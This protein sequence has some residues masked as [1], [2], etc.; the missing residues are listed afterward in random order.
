MVGY[1]NFSE[2]DILYAEIFNSVWLPISMMI[3][4]KVGNDLAPGGIV[5]TLYLTVSNLESI[6]AFCI[7]KNM[8][9]GK[10]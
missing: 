9:I 7:L 1:I 5:D 8:F 3:L 10:L 6:C 4:V 2:N